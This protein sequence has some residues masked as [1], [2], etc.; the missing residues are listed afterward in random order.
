M[1]SMGKEAP[2]SAQ[3]STG[4]ALCL[5]FINTVEWRKS[6]RP[7]EHLR[8]YADVVAWARHTERTS[9]ALLSEQE[10]VR[11]LHAAERQPERAR[12]ALV[13]AITVR[14][15]LYRLF[16]AIARNQTPAED[17]LATL[18]RALARAMAH[19][20]I[21]RLASGYA[22]MWADETHLDRVLWPVVRSAME[23][24][25]AGDLS[26]VSECADEWCGWLFYDTSKNRI[27]RWC[28]MQSCGNRAKARRHYARLRGASA[29]DAAHS[30]SDPR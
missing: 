7:V 26:R 1:S 10:A 21:T 24:L 23:L 29:P 20:R 18:N 11:L 30:S 9:G 12:A 6:D 25:T 15:A 16:R 3:E 2:G 4:V 27:R 13:E 22:W 8:D 17:D 19:G 14:E 28:S 5:D